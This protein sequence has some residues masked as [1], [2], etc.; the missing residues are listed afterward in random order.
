M[1]KNIKEILTIQ[2]V[3]NDNFTQLNNHT[4]HRFIHPEKLFV[5]YKLQSI[6]QWY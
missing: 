5:S 4:P 1:E 6:C 3:L 2:I